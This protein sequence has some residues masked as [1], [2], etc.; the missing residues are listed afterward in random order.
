MYHLRNSTSEFLTARLRNF[1]GVN[2]AID[3]VRVVNISCASHVISKQG[4]VSYAAAY[5]PQRASD[6]L[7]ARAGDTSGWSCFAVRN[8]LICDLVSSSLGPCQRSL[9]CH[10]HVHVLIWI[11][12]ANRQ[13]RNRDSVR[14]VIQRLPN[15]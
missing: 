2:F 10:L 11:A 1:R 13:R 8:C 4:K 14:R 9:F 15:L 12:P 7:N 5:E 3:I 6:G